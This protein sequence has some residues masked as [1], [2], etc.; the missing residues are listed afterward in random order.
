M[1]SYDAAVQT[2]LAESRSALD[3]EIASFGTAKIALKTYV[4]EQVKSRKLLHFGIYKSIG[5]T[6]P[7]RSGAKPYAIRLNPNS[8]PGVKI[9]TDMHITYLKDLLYVMIAEDLQRPNAATARPEDNK[10]VRRLPVISELFLNPESVRL[11]RIQEVS[12]TLTLTLNPNPYLYFNPYTIPNPKASIAAMA[13]PVDNP[14]YNKLVDEYMGKILYD[15]GY[16]RVFSIQ[17]VA[18]KGTNR[19][20]CWEATSEPVHKEEGEWVVHQRHLVPMEDGTRVLKKSAMVGFALAEYALGDDVDPVRLS[21]TDDCH[22]KFL[23]REARLASA[24]TRLPTSH[25]KRRQ[26]PTYVLYYR[27]LNP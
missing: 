15:G 4:L 1:D 22:D 27:T 7:F 20:P 26:P 23:T 12:P 5:L 18:N 21:F 9:T 8:K 3:G 24:Q 25:R 13:S 17:F 2:P 19:Y 14:I 11:K 10:L 16:Y 6:S